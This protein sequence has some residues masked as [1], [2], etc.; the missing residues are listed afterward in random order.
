[1]H[2]SAYRHDAD[3]STTTQANQLLNGS[4]AQGEFFTSDPRRRSD[5]RLLLR[6][7]C[8]CSSPVFGR[9]LGDVLGQCLAAFHGERV[10]DGGTETTYGTVSFQAVALQ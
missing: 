4:P 9:E 6:S 1:M 5:T 3:V 2:I 10:V 7:A 8:F